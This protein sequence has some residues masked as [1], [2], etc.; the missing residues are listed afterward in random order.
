M[1]LTIPEKKLIGEFEQWLSESDKYKTFSFYEFE[2]SLYC[3]STQRS[4][5]PIQF[6]ALDIAKIYLPDE[7]QGQGWFSWFVQYLIKL[8]HF[9]LLHV[10]SVQNDRFGIK[11]LRDGWIL[12]PDNA[13]S[14]F[15]STGRV[16][17]NPIAPITMESW[18]VKS[19][20]YSEAIF[21]YH[22]LPEY[23]RNYIDNY[24]GE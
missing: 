18:Y 21:G 11:L 22:D 24:S 16:I 2:Y 3:R 1:E 13:K 6:N 23:I 15:L 7:R 19:L 9:E 10:E 8:P 14:F 5:G 20:L 4:I 17:K 12:A